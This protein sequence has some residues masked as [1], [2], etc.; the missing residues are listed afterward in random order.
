[1]HKE[2]LEDNEKAAAQVDEGISFRLLAKKSDVEDINSIE[3]DIEL[4]TGELNTQQP[5][6]KLENIVQL[7]GFTD[8]I[9]AEA[10]ISVHQYDILLDILIVNQTGETLRDLSIDFAT[11][12]DL[13]LVEKPR[14]YNVGPHSFSSVKA[15]IKVSS[16]ETGVIFGNIVYEGTGVGE[17]HCVVLNDIHIDI[18][19]YIKPAYCDE[20]AFH[21]MWTEFEW[22]NKVNVNTKINDLNTY[23]QHVMKLTNMGC[24][25]PEKTFANDCGFLSAN[26]Y[27]R[28]I[29]G[30][31]ALAN[32]SI[33]K[34]GDGPIIGHVRIRSKTQGIALSLGDKITLS[35]KQD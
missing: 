23:L 21:S 27:A 11:L 15:N 4:A 1:M 24:L 28:S 35:Q 34:C 8:P 17:S 33:E 6:S 5:V 7:T 14:S 16:T 13:K 22:E 29:F 12:G 31:D 2:K 3:N 26:L 19:E 25:T 18:M 10:Y 32:I 9:Y 20:R 30:E